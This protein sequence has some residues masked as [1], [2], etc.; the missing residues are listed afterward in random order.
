MPN[1]VFLWNLCSGRPVCRLSPSEAQIKTVL[2]RMKICFW[3]NITGLCWVSC[4]M[5]AANITAGGFASK[6]AYSCSR[7]VKNKV[8]WEKSERAGRGACSA[9]MPPQSHAVF[10]LL[11]APKLVFGCIILTQVDTSRLLFSLCCSSSVTFM[12]SFVGT[13][14]VSSINFSWSRNEK[15]SI[16][17]CQ[18]VFSSWQWSSWGKSQTMTAIVKGQISP[19]GFASDCMFISFWSIEDSK[20]LSHSPHSLNGW[21]S[22]CHWNRLRADPEDMEKVAVCHPSWKR[23]VWLCLLFIKPLL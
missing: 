12:Y 19:C 13:L 17:F 2:K 4:C 5:F 9:V 15:L 7:W 22:A 11:C 1:A 16:F 3:K 14:G 8:N 6:A 20:P 10:H 18:R 21:S 23:Q